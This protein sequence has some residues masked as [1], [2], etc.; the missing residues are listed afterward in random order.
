MKRYVLGSADFL[1]EMVY[2]KL[3][4]FNWYSLDKFFKYCVNMLTGY[5]WIVK[6]NEKDRERPFY[7]EQHYREVYGKYFDMFEFYGIKHEFV[8][9]DK[10]DKFVFSLDDKHSFVFYPMCDEKKNSSRL[11]SETNTV[12]DPRYGVLVAYAVDNGKATKL[13]WSCNHYD[14]AD[15]NFKAYPSKEISYNK[16]QVEAGK[17]ASIMEDYVKSWGLD[18]FYEKKNEELVELIDDTYNKLIEKWEKARIER[19]ERERKDKI[20]REVI[21]KGAIMTVYFRGEEVA[22]MEGTNS[23]NSINN[24]RY[25]F[26]MN[27]K[28]TLQYERDNK[29]HPDTSG[30]NNLDDSTPYVSRY[31][32]HNL[33]KDHYDLIECYRTHAGESC[34]HCGKTPIVNI[35]VIRNPK[36]E[37][38]HVG[39][40]CVSHLVDLPLEEFEEEWNAPFREASNMIAK[41]RNDKKKSIDGTWYKYGNKCYYVIENKDMFDYQLFNGCYLRERRGVFCSSVHPTDKVLKRDISYIEKG[42]GFTKRMFPRWYSGAIETQIN[43]KDL[44]DMLYDGRHID[45]RNFT[46]DGVEYKIPTSDDMR[47]HRDVRP[48][49][50]SDKDFSVGLYSQKF[51]DVG[52]DLKNATYTFGD[53][54]IEY[55]WVIEE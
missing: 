43:I 41:V 5:I 30:M 34:E 16:V 27:A 38:F 31:T 7:F 55:K 10:G 52:Y 51:E 40:E 29:I 17:I 46:Y 26:S 11:N 9:T 12:S 42:A 33:P 2:C 21:R 14:F 35:M 1:N 54:T 18:K 37:I 6:E 50:L 53:L 19:E 8:K 39:N 22:A 49:I 15:N 36:G 28:Y 47:I 20:R 25:A 24:I 32:E 48:H 44:I 13:D 23:I 45:F 3:K 4:T